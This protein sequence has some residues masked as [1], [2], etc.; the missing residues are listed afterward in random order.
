MGR[1][2]PEVRRL[3]DVAVLVALAAVPGAA[4]QVPLPAADAPHAH[5]VAPGEK[6]GTVDFPVS[7]SSAARA[8]FGRATALLHSFPYEQAELAFGQVLSADPPPALA[9]SPLAP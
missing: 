7:C 9:P 6:L 5:S 3:L 1:A 2:G 8:K 4:D